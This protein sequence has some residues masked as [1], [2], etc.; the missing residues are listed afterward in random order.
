MWWTLLVALAH[1]QATPD[2]APCPPLGAQVD[3]AWA[4]YRDAEVD[5]AKGVLQE[6]YVSLTCQSGVLTA[7][8]LLALYRL[9]ALVSITQDDQKGAVYATLRSVAAQ[10]EGAVPPEAYGPSL[11]ELYTTWSER[12]GGTLVDVR[13]EGGG[14]V[15]VDGRRLTQGSVLSVAEG[16]H[17]VQIRVDETV[18]SEVV[19]LSDAYVVTTGAPGAPGLPAF[20]APPTPAPA[21]SVS[22]PVAVAPT[23]APDRPERSRRRPAWAFAAAGLSAGGAA[24]ALGSAVV[25]ETNFHADP[26]VGLGASRADVIRR[27][28]QAIRSVYL[29]GYGLSAVSVGLL[30][31]GVVGL[32]THDAPMTVGIGRRW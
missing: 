10:H 2:P 8:E 17:V 30:S 12:L 22:A 3:A 16:E 18:R 13:V 32:P 29:V 14:E 7:E 15:F 23:P 20:T 26:Y 24:F 4:A 5:A 31:V 27:D 11:A 6:A 25:S 9:D 21:P 28:A 19:D 1:G